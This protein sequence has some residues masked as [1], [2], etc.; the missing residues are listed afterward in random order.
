MRYPATGWAYLMQPGAPLDSTP[1]QQGRF[2]LSGQAPAG[3][4]A[5]PR[6]EAEEKAIF[7]APERRSCPVRA[8]KNWL[9]V[10][11]QHGRTAG[12]LFLSEGPAP[13]PA[14]TEYL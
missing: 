5:R 4:Q 10:L 11:K 12:L 13:E 1:V 14:A 8:V 6:N 2:R 3:G 9:A 7:F